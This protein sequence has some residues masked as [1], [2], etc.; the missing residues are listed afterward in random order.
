MKTVKQKLETKLAKWEKEFPELIINQ[1]HLG[2]KD[3]P[4]YNAW[5]STSA[6][7]G[8]VILHEWRRLRH[9][10]SVWNSLDLSEPNAVYS[11]IASYLRQSKM[12]YYARLLEKELR[13]QK[14]SA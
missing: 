3:H 6:K 1:M 2:T 10:L 11:N 7:V 8:M 14:K 13:Q 5:L 4:N 9:I 12:S